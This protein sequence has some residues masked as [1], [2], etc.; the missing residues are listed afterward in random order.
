MEAWPEAAHPGNLHP[1]PDPLP[2][3]NLSIHSLAPDCPSPEPRQSAARET[4][5][6]RRSPRA[7]PA[8]PRN[9]ISAQFR[10]PGCG[11][12]AS[13]NSCAQPNQAGIKIANKNIEALRLLFP[14]FAT[15]LPNFA[16]LFLLCLRTAPVL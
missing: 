14:K 13:A 9:T 11:L 15:R 6:L 1:A 5:T 2:D 4:P 3:P 7:I 12:P 16:L 8:S 10:A